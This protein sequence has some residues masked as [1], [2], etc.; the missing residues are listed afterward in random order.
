MT[1]TNN[2]TTLVAG[3]KFKASSFFRPTGM[4]DAMAKAGIIP[5]AHIVRDFS[6]TAL[7]R[8]HHDRMDARPSVRVAF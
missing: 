4:G 7:L 1:K 6:K 2:N 5:A 8:H 3:A